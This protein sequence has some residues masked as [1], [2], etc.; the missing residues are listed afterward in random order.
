[1]NSEQLK[2]I[3]ELVKTVSVIDTVLSHENRLR[4]IMVCKQDVPNNREA[5]HALSTN[6]VDNALLDYRDK[7]K[8]ELKELGYGE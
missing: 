6:L 5:M 4:Y 1:M 2:K 7:L 8:V 3:N